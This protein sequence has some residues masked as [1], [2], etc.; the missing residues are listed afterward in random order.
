[1]AETYSPDLRI[2]LIGDGDLSGTWGDVTN[3]NLGT[4]I[5]DAIAGNIAISVTTA[6]QAF[7]VVNGA[8]DQARMASITLST[9]TGAAFAVYA[10]PVP[11]LYVI[12]NTSIYVATIYNSTISG[13]TSPAGN[14]VTIPA[15]ASVAVWSDGTNFYTQNSTFGSA[16]PVQGAVAYSNGT[17]ISYT[18]VGTAGQVLLSNGTSAPSWGGAQTANAVTFNNSGTGVASG[19]SFNGSVA[20]TVSYNTIGAPSTTGVNASGTWGINIS[21]TAAT[22]SQTDF[23]NLT[24]GGSQVL[25][26]ANYNTYA[27]TLTGTGAS[28]T[29]GINI[30]GNAATASSATSAITA[31]NADYLVGGTANGIV[32]QSAANTTAFIT[33]PSTAGTYLSWNG[34]SFGWTPPL[35]NAVH[36]VTS[37]RTSGISYTNSNGVPMHVNIYTVGGNFQ[38]IVA[39]A[40]GVEVVN[41]NS[42]SSGGEANAAFIVPAGASYS[43]TCSSIAQWVETY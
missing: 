39:Y 37:S 7:T 36:N 41:A 16:A 32:Y 4:L 20:E 42:G 12:Y 33:A 34:V 43:A 8:L 19:A 6:N 23:T 29:W 28:G 30:S 13:N 9:T 26:A 31:I 22:T 17:S 14:G 40:G 5:E 11:K 1:M 35:F 15:G 21:G 2:T 24:I 27:P 25:D 18:A 3:T 38:T 10:P